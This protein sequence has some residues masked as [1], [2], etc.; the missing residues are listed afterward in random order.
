[1]IGPG[2]ES[3]RTGLVGIISKYTDIVVNARPSGLQILGSGKPE[4]ASSSQIIIPIDREMWKPYD[5]YEVNA[6]L[7]LPA[8]YR[9]SRG[10]LFAN[11]EFR[12]FSPDITFA[13]WLSQ[14]ADELQNALDQ[15]AN[16]AKITA[17]LERSRL[18][19]DVNK[20]VARY[21]DP[22]WTDTII[23]IID[24]PP[25]ATCGPSNL[26]PVLNRREYGWCRFGELIENCN[27]LPKWEYFI[28]KHLVLQSSG[29]IKVDFLHSLK[30]PISGPPDCP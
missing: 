14:L 13:E 8:V 1:M 29:S 18:I 26:D 19:I 6:R 5:T 25:H 15:V 27:G 9:L 28:P 3:R 4:A 7:L 17:D 12:Q 30:F 22:R 21:L 23:A 10:N 16:E 20:E 2:S 24:R 11:F